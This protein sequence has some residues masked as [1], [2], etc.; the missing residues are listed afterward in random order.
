MH[1]HVSNVHCSMSHCPISNIPLRW[2]LTATASATTTTTTI[3]TTMT[4]ALITLHMQ[5]APSATATALII[6][7]RQWRQE[8]RGMQL[9]KLLLH[10]HKP[11]PANAPKPHSS[12]APS[13]VYHINHKPINSPCLRSDKQLKLTTLLYVDRPLSPVPAHIV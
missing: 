7:C 6:E 5:I 8:Q 12:T 10:V 3:T 11:A 2:W 1:F 4:T 9:G 13:S